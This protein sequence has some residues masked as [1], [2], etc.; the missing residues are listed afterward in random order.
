MHRAIAMSRADNTAVALADLAAGEALEVFAGEDTIPITLAEPVGFGHKFALSAIAGGGEVLKYG[1]VIGLAA[2]D[3]APGHHVHVHNV[4][5][6]RA[7]GD[8][9]T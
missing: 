6:V 1:A 3:I 5:S 7:R 9:P 8:R 2:H 4:E